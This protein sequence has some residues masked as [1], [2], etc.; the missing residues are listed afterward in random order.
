MADASNTQDRDGPAVGHMTLARRAVLLCVCIGLG[1]GIG[2]AGQTYSGDSSWFLAVPAC[3]VI[4]WS[5]VADP[6]QCA[7]PRD[8]P[9]R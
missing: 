8:P 2:L 7:R 4:G 3:M 1:L 9:R 5:F 6:T